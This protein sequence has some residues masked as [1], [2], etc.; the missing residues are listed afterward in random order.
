VRQ[1]DPDFLFYRLFDLIPGTYFFAKNRKGVVMFTNRA[2]L[3]DIF[4]SEGIKELLGFS[5]Y[6]LSPAGLAESYLRDDAHIYATGETLVNR[7]ELW[8]DA[9][10]LPT[11]FVTNKMPVYSRAGKIIGI[12]GFG[13]S[14]EQ[15]A[16]LLPS[17]DG[18]AKMVAHFRQHFPQSISMRQMAQLSGFSQ[19]Q[20]ERRFLESFGVTPQRFLIK[21]RLM[22]AC[23]RL[24]KTD[25][26]LAEI[27]QA[28]G[29]TDQSAFGRIF[30]LHLGCTPSE[31]RRARKIP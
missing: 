31:F 22:E 18:I 27:A 17:S 3:R 24:L 11:W 29:F 1:I 25:R 20:M 30:R 21:T 15:R 10:G 13:Q 14:Y 16:K 8:F 9:M 28:C 6:D 12:M 7:V 23:D 5:D 4:H 2:V 19:R 26:G